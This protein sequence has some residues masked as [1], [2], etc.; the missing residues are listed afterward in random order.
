M[1]QAF[2][3]LA[4]TMMAWNQVALF[5]GALLLLLLGGVIVADFIYWRVRAQRFNGVITGIR[6]GQGSSQRAIYYP[7]IAYSTLDGETITADTDSGS[8][9]LANKIPGRKV[10]VMVLPRDVE[11]ARIK[12]TIW[13]VIG[14]LI[15]AFGVG[16]LTVAIDFSEINGTTVV[17]VAILLV[18]G[19]YKLKAS[20]K[21]KSQRQDK[22]DFRARKKSER[23]AKRQAMPLLNKQEVMQI[24]NEHDRAN[25][26]LLPWMLGLGLMVFGGGVYLAKDLVSLMIVAERADGRVVSLKRQYNANS[27]GSSYTYYPVVEYQNLNG[28]TIRFQDKVGSSPATDRRG[29]RVRVIYDPDNADRVRIDRGLW[30]WLVSGGCL[31]IGALLVGASLNSYRH[32]SRRVADELDGLP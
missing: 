9:S 29:D 4:T 20:I 2:E 11:T 16:L 10:S 23:Q 6:R 31:A 17:I 12:S 21:P 24:L 3:L 32:L 18:W 25:K 27:E 5:C 8:S 15:A 14:T 28:E 19:F 1:N 22:A 30:N 7:V 26:K 13:G